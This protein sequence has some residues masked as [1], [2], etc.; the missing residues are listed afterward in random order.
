[1]IRVMWLKA[2]PRCGGDL[3]AE[4]DFY[5]SYISC[6]ACGYY[7]TEAEEVVLRYEPRRRQ[8]IHSLKKR[9]EE[10]EAVSAAA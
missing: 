7:L 1:M 4:R 5:G 9:G 6:L 3:T 2:C 8:L 10:R